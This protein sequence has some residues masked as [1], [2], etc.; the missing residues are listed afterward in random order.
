MLKKI[1]FFLILIGLFMPLPSVAQSSTETSTELKAIIGENQSVAVDRKIV[2]DASR[3]KGTTDNT[4]YTWD[5]GDGQ[6]DY[7]IDVI[8]SYSTPGDYT[9][10]LQLTDGN[11]N[12]EAELVVSVYEDLIV[13][14]SDQ[15]Y[16]EEQFQNL[17]N[18]AN[19]QGVLLI[20]VTTTKKEADYIVEE[21]LAEELLTKKEDLQKADIIMVYTKGNTGLNALSNF[22]KSIENSADLD[23]NNKAIVYITKESLSPTARIAQ[24][25]FDI[26]GPQYIL[27]AREEIMQQVVDATKLDEPVTS[28]RSI[29]GEQYL[30]GI[31]SHRAVKELGITNFMSYTIN[32]LVN[33]GVS[34]SNLVLIL[35]LPIIATIIAFAR[36]ILGIKTFGIYTPSIIALAF[37]AAGLKYGL[38]IF[39][40][41]LVT[42]TIF[43]LFI[44][45]FRLTYLP[46]I[47]IVLTI[48][49]LTILGAFV[50]GAY[51]GRTGFIAVSALPILVMIMMVE[52]FIAVQAE[53]GLLTAIFLSLETILV[54]VACYLVV[55]WEAFETLIL[56]YPELILLTIL[57]NIFL[58]KWSGLRLSEYFR[59]KEVRKYIKS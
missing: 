48:V 24:G 54:S 32:Y 30:V 18:Y 28:V 20:N 47:A 51:T 15:S 26:L 6:K 9:V 33:K 25:T 58:G 50:L 43:R 22:A 7:G 55:K 35:M 36:Q 34:I 37:I 57:I 23:I 39:L 21:S 5:F 16:S 41:M 8:H 38:T 56:G 42:A 44:K 31:H 17:K 1:F 45:K 14:L 29:S 53:R 4:N 12:S 13:L 49:S 10:T 52:K 3:S 19:K 46:R 40:L 11:K 27:L 2:L 59:F